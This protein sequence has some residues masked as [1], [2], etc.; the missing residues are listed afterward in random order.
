MASGIK[1]LSTI[2]EKF[3]INNFIDMSEAED[4][5]KNTD[6]MKD[7]V[8][9]IDSITGLIGDILKVVTSIVNKFMDIFNSL[10]ALFNGSFIKGLIDWLTGFISSNLSG[11]GFSLATS[12]DF[13]NMFNVA[14]TNLANTLDNNKLGMSGYSFSIIATLNALMCIGQEGSYTAMKEVLSS[15][16]TLSDNEVNDLLGGSISAVLS[17]PNKNSISL[18]NEISSI[19]LGKSILAYDPN[20]TQNALNAANEDTSQADF[21]SLNDSLVTIDP[22]FT[23]TSNTFIFNGKDKYKELS[24]QSLKSSVP[25]I[26][27][28][29]DIDVRLLALT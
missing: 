18:I 23:Q 24:Q 20:F 28:P 17:I 14:C 19:D 4:F 16:D 27:E 15:S 12:N 3:N 7:I 13:K 8:L 11:F 1:T 6:I 22:L 25:D 21:D 10:K 29:S 26:N 2:D 5:L 9:A